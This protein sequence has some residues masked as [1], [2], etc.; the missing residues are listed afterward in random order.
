MEDMDAIHYI[1]RLERECEAYQAEYKR[2]MA[3]NAKLRKLWAGALPCLRWLFE[4]RCGEDET[5]P[6]GTVDYMALDELLA[7]TSGPVVRSEEEHSDDCG[8]K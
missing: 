8:E 2:L 5:L 6:L 1:G 4:H 7:D 3:E